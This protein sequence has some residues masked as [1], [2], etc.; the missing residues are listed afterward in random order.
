VSGISIDGSHENWIAGNYIGTDPSGTQA[1][2][3]HNTGIGIRNEASGNLIGTNGD[4][5]SDAN[6]RNVISGNTYGIALD[7]AS[8][9]QVQGNYIGVTAAGN[10]AVPNK[11]AG[12]YVSGG[13]GNR[14]GITT[15][16]GPAYDAKRNVISGNFWGVKLSDTD[17][18]IIAGNY[19]GTNPAGTQ[20]LANQYVGIY[21]NGGAGNLIG[22]DGDGVADAMERNVIS[23]NGGS[24]IYLS[25]S[26]DNIIAGNYI[27][28]NAAG[29]AALG[30]GL[31]GVGVQDGDAN[32]IGMDDVAH[33][34]E[35]NV[36]SANY[37][38]GIRLIN[39]NANSIS[40][41][42]IGTDATGTASLG[43]S[44]SGISIYGASSFNNMVGNMVPELGNV[45]AYNQYTGVRMGEYGGGVYPG[46][47]LYNAILSN[48]I[49]SNGYQGITLEPGSNNG[50]NHPDVISATTTGSVIYVDAQ[51]AQG[52]PLRYVI[53]QFF[54]SSTC[55]PSG[56]GEGKEL[57]GSATGVTDA[58]G[59]LSLSGS[60]PK[61]VSIEQVVT[62]TAT[63]VE[64]G[65]EAYS[66]D[67]S[68]CVPVTR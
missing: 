39:A 10:A 32:R 38:S 50:L 66:S 37:D 19:I 43:N 61:A 46:I 53:V 3:E 21:I 65:G 60:F 52:P 6:E 18:N 1:V 47:P 28:T 63:V 44:F 33:T 56:Y 12:I 29:S 5:V 11:N 27:G 57:L 45:I 23:G 48:A 54:A 41:N 20:A 40:G 8:G 67:F 55:D 34:A 68:A 42:L 36:I 9:T 58:S 49:F 35:R 16:A 22:T 64:G 59:N 4:G 15:T 13:W 17:D 2:G 24:G 31:M 26:S 30:N 7:D 14:I 51:I 25:A 62:A